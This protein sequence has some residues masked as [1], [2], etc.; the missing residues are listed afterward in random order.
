MVTQIRW[1]AVLPAAVAGWF[2]ALII[3]LIVHSGIES[4]CP[5]NQMDSGMC[6][7]PWFPY[8][9]DAVSAFGAGLAAVLVISLAVLAAPT[10]R[11]VVTR[12]AFVGGLLVAIYMLWQ[13]SAIVEFVAAVSCGLLTVYVLQRYL[14]PPE[15]P[16]PAFESELPS[17]A[18]QRER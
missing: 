4:L 15:S 13:T 9:S 18:A 14:R 6:V 11:I 2:L 12:T 3:G 8:A 5:R 17:A 16:N 1:L 10:H 7:A